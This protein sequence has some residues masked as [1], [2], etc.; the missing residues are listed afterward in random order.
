[1]CKTNNYEGSPKIINQ[2]HTTS[3]L[4]SFLQC[5]MLGKMVT[6]SQHDILKDTYQDPEKYKKASISPI[7]LQTSHYQTTASDDAWK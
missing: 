4:P 3:N 1:M 7:H 6:T 2:L 5:A